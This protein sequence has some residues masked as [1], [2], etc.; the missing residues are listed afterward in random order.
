M[1]KTQLHLMNLLALAALTSIFLFVPRTSAQNALAQDDQRL[2]NDATRQAQDKYAARPSQDQDNNAT[3]QDNDATRGQLAR[4]DDFLDAH[5]EIAEQLRKNPSLVNN[6]DFVT[7]HPALQSFLQDQPGV[8][9]QL[10]QNP[11]AFMQQENTFDR[12]EDA[13]NNRATDLAGDANRPGDRV[14]NTRVADRD[15]NARPTDR[16]DIRTADRD[17]NRTGDVNRAGQNGRQDVHSNNSVV[18]PDRSVSANE[19][20]VSIAPRGQD[21]HGQFGE[22]LGSHSNISKDLSKNPSLVNNHDYVQ[23]HPELQAYLNNHPDVRDQLMQNPQDFMK[24][25][26]QPST[27]PGADTSQPPKAP[28]VNSKPSK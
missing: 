19:R 12:R 18:S 27:T 6:K 21:S 25:A 4:F 9:D 3:R 10:R 20:S 11:S 2:D 26:Q 1:K 24:Q 16:D 7:K 28:P 22:F 13:G 14:N 5:P 8:R 17:D 23:K 15:N